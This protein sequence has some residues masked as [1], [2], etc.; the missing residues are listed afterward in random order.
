MEKTN[1]KYSKTELIE[2]IKKYQQIIYLYNQYPD[3]E[4]KE[5]S[6][7]EA[8]MLLEEYNKEYCKLLK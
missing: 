6:Y 3:Y 1:K 8:C 4:N 7:T 5:Y 2:L